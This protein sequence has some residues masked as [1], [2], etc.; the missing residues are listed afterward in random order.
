MNNDGRKIAPFKRK[1]SSTEMKFKPNNKKIKY[2][3][4]F[5]K[6]IE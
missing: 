3:A 2:P 6:K 1:I 4:G 5:K